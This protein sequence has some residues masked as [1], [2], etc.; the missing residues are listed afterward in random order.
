MTK[1]EALIADV[2]AGVR[3]ITPEG[4]VWRLSK[5]HGE[6]VTDRKWRR[7]VVLRAQVQLKYGSAQ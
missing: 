1:T 3:K 2:K 7:D 4:H 5:L 6:W